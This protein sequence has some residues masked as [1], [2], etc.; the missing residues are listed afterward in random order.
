M[1]TAVCKADHNK[2]R[3]QPSVVSCRGPILYLM[4]MHKSV[5]IESLAH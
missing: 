4:Y 1:H 5:V 2:E 3:G